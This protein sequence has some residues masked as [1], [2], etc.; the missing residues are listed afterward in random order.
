MRLRNYIIPIF[1]LIFCTSLVTHTKAFAQT[2]TPNSQ[3][4]PTAT[5]EPVI[6]SKPE[7]QIIMLRFK[8]PGIG[9]PGGNTSPRNVSRVVRLY[10]FDPDSNTDDDTVKPIGSVVGSADF[11]SDPN[12]ATFGSFINSNIDLG[13]KI[14]DGRYQIAFK[15]DQALSK[16]IKEDSKD[17]GGKIYEIRNSSRPIDIDGQEIIIGDIY[18]DAKGDNVMDINDYNALV[19]CFGTKAESETCKD[20]KAADLNDDGRI[21]GIDYNV[22]FGSFK[23]LHSMGKPVPSFIAPTAAI[24]PTKKVEK[25]KAQPSPKKEVLEKPTKKE[26]GSLSIILPIMVTIIFLGIVAFLIIKRRKALDFLGKL[27][28]KNSVAADGEEVEDEVPADEPDEQIE[29]DFFVKKQT[30]DKTNNTT[31]LTLTDDSGPMLGYYSGK[32]IADGFAHVK[33]VMK[34]EGNKVFVDVSEITP[35]EEETQAA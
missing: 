25:P 23:L 3:S 5:V 7:G 11:D 18:P 33:G 32:E 14:P 17:I 30:E 4:D 19:S 1:L 15:M 34:K 10:F 21:N 28:H 12:S 29:K 27:I 2:I 9:E 26:A 6:T 8:I 31:V 16:L 35:V 13:D 24:K 20:N 22:M